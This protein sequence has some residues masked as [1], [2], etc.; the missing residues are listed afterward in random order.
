MFTINEIA[1]E[2]KRSFFPRIHY[3]LSRNLESVCG[4]KGEGIARAAVRNYA[5]AC[6]DELRCMH[7]ADGV[8]TNARSYYLASDK[9]RDTRERGKC[10]FL[11]Q[12]VC[13]N[14][15]YTCPYA[16]IWDRY[17]ASDYGI[18]FCEEFEKA[19]FES[20]TKGVGQMHLSSNMTEKRFNECRFAIY[21]RKANITEAEAAKCFDEDIRKHSETEAFSDKYYQ[22]EGKQCFGLLCHYLAAAIDKCGEEG[23]CAVVAGLK[24]LRKDAVDVL[25]DQSVRTLRALDGT[26][27]AENFPLPLDAGSDLYKS[28]VC[29][30]SDETAARAAE[31]LERHLLTPIAGSLNR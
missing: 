20:Y 9:E 30:V 23:V 28:S 24:E 18:W 26:F 22:D 10:L 16:D 17:G 29:G 1:I 4:R 7:E 5:A 13:I 8:K 19:K 25:A 11:D 21:F 6:G 2:N 31:L 14:E 12:E 3:F 15:V 27:A